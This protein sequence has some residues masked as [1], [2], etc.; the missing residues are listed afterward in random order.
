MTDIA[1]MKA[2]MKPASIVFIAVC[3]L[4]IFGRSLLLKWN[5]SPAP[6]LYGNA[7][8]FGVTLLAMYFELKG[9]RSSN[10]YAFFR[11]IYIGMLLKLFLSAGVV[12]VYALTDREALT[13]GVVLV[14]LCLYAVYSWLE[15]STLIR[16]G[17]VKQ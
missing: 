6:I 14:W 5:V 9:V 16:A 4:A 11:F 2:F 15:V 3:L 8:L 12:L 17:K 10:S 7:W 13:G 1:G